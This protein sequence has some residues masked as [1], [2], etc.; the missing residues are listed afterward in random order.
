MADII[1]HDT[2]NITLGEAVFYAGRVASI[3]RPAGV[4]S[5]V[6]EQDLSGFLSRS[7]GKVKIYGRN[8]KEIS[9]FYK[10]RILSPNI[11]NRYEMVI[12]YLSEKFVESVNSNWDSFMNIDNS[13]I[14]HIMSTFFNK[15]TKTALMYRM[16]WSGNDPFSGSILLNF[17]AESSAYD[18]VVVPVRVL[19]KMASPGMES[20]I[21]GS[22]IQVLTPPIPVA[23]KTDNG[24]TISVGNL[25]EYSG[26][27]L[28]SVEVEWGS[29]MSTS[30]H[31][32]HAEVTLRYQLINPV[33]KEDFE[34]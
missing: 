32:L 5:G 22:K 19:Q 14:D 33:T 15:S 17:D 7:G 34:V 2:G 3:H 18:E 20:V 8:R 26:V 9:D 27:I 23:Q 10:I 30:G 4:G 21:E 11:N 12:S 6:V 24:V 28:K 29:K 13:T 31:P 25:F 16:M 1:N